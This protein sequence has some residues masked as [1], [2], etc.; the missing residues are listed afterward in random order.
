MMIQCVLNMLILLTA[1]GCTNIFAIL[2]NLGMSTVSC[3]C[4]ANSTKEEVKIT[5]GLNGDNDDL[6]AASVTDDSRHCT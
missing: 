3:C 4:H 1:L 6:T 5:G 2:T